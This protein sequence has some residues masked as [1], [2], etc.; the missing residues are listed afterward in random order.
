MA[1]DIELV[2]E[3]ERWWDS[4]NH[5][6]QAKIGAAIDLLEEYGPHLKFPYS[7]G[8]ATSRH[9]QMRE[10]RIQHLGRPYRVLYAFDSRRTGVLLLG[11][12]KTGNERW[13]EQNIPLADLRFDEHL[14]RK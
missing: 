4:L 12:D 3:F 10:L 8:I 9:A 6:E 2:E 14:A 13:Y 1:W 7:S 5:D 11:G